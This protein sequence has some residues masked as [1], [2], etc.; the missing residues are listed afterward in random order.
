M[1]T[2]KKK[3][4][5]RAQKLVDDSRAA[6]KT[7]S[8]GEKHNPERPADHWY[9]ETLTGDTLFLV[10]YTQAC[11]WSQCTG[12]NLPSLLSKK[13]VSFEKIMRQVD[14]VFGRIV[15]RERARRLKKI[16]LSNNGSVLD[17]RT[18]STTAL[19]YFV[20]KMNMHCPNIRVL[21]LESRAEYIDEIELEV[22][23][24]AL[25]EGSREAQLEL[26]IGFE[27]FDSR[28]RNRVFRK[29]LSLK[30]FE[31][32]V[33]RAAHHGFHI[34]AYFM[35]KPVPDMSEEEAIQDVR[36]GLEYLDRLAHKYDATINLHLNPTY[37]AR[38]T[39]LER[40][41][42]AG[43][44]SPPLLESLQRAALQAK[45]KRVSLYLG[46]Y[47]EGLAV[48]GGSFVR[49]GDERLLRCLSR[50]NKA[51]DYSLLKACPIGAPA[52]K[53]RW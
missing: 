25:R 17:E 53:E 14:H 44:Y 43:R 10:L 8:F 33:R 23:A 27:V 52:G 46:L 39:V 18:F 29:G 40:D 11:L 50:F 51:Q 16:I 12:C 31:R 35:L 22:L 42:K 7:Y 21:T 2:A 48:P 30:T 47:D 1:S 19:M 32:T 3:K 13:H 41:F 28:I 5:T 6:G 15:P 20:A 4:R 49:R 26:A 36:R 34:K 38:G 45:G 37:V 24:R 9:Q